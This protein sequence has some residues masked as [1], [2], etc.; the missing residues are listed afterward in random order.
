MTLKDSTGMSPYMLV[1]GNE[2]KMLINLELNSLTY[3][4][5]L[6]DVEDTPPMQ[7]RLNQLLRLE[8]ERSEAL[9]KY[10]RGNIML[11]NISIKVKQ[12]RTF[13]R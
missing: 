3:A 7:K 9:K 12:S 10:H 11:R 8:E 4:V 2:A 1:Y 6:E 5:N 13:K